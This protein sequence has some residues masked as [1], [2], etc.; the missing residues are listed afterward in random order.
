MI[1]KIFSL[2]LLIVLLNSCSNT[3]QLDNADKKEL[4][5]ITCENPYQIWNI[6]KSN[7][8]LKWVV[9]SD[10][11]KS[12]SSPIAWVISYL[13]CTSWKKVY[14]KTL[15]A[16]VNPDFNN[17]NISNLSIQK[18]SLVSQKANIESLK[19]T[20]ITNFDNQI[21][22]LKWQIDILKKNMD[23]TKKSWDL[24]RLDLEKQIETLEDTL[25]SLEKN[26]DLLNKSKL[27]ALK[28]IE[29]NKNSTYI[30]I[31]N[32]VKDN[33]LKI[34]EIF[35][36]TKE[37]KDLNDKYENY[38]SKKDSIL[39]AEVKSD[40]RELDNLD[41]TQMSDLEISDFLWKLIILDDKAKESVKKSI[42]NIYFS[43]TQIDSFYS[44]FLNYS[45]NITDLKN[46]W[47][48]IENS[49]T[50]TIT[51]FDTQISSLESQITTTKNNLENLKDNKLGTI[52]N[53]NEIQISNLESQLKTLNTNLDNLISNKKSQIIN[54]DNQ[55]LQLNQSISSLN[56]N[57]SSRN[58]YAWISGVI[59]QKLSSKWNTIWPNVPICQIIPNAKST[60]I[61]IYSPVE[62]SIWDKLT[63]ELK[64]ELY[65][66]F[67]ENALVYKDAITQNFVYESNYLDR[68]YFKD[69][70]IINLSFENND[71]EKVIEKNIEWTKIIPVSY[72]KNKIDW[73]YIKI[74]SW[75][76]LIDKKVELWDINWNTVEIEK[77]IENIIQICK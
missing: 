63:F 13:N 15:I 60:K 73:N 38:L 29:T 54:F 18:A 59:K 40:F 28:S 14:P 33:L 43:Q 26:L 77:G 39:L 75:S 41:I 48:S 7:L 49:K 16:K 65:E 62:L 17:P 5:N 44:I 42:V 37:N 55:I 9:V 30:N 70:E 45:K 69:W 72:V 56:S 71:S 2:I 25:T 68:K 12:I 21:S 24:S 61:K 47:D 51:N 1:K 32:I 36:I 23:L 46:A 19:Q 27:E 50:S 22:D 57:L 6:D 76:L 58:I 67:I 11:T 35:W 3:E 31:K 20:T 8:E 66:V 4:S 34:D 64:W 74:L 10:D 52:D 53:W